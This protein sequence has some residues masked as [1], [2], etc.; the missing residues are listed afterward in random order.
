MRITS[1]KTMDASG[2]A[3]GRTAAMSTAA[4]S[5]GSSFQQAL[6]EDSGHT[7]MAPRSA[8]AS[9]FVAKRTKA[10]GS[11]EKTA[12]KL[13]GNGPAAWVFTAVPPSPV[14]V[15]PPSQPAGSLSSPNGQDAAAET[16]V[17]SGEYVD[18]IAP[19]DGGS[20]FIPLESAVA[21]AAALHS[22]IGV[23]RGSQSS[24]DTQPHSENFGVRASAVGSSGMPVVSADAT[25]QT[26]PKSLSSAPA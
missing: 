8:A 10:G 25:S 14:Q 22:E 18:G 20:A 12:P 17:P 11:G 4:P 9:D 1:A 6:A 15:T 26:G 21:D 2:T 16:A 13:P 3:T 23:S 24:P 5:F 7:E 19:Q